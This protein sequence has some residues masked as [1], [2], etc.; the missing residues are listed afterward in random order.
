VIHATNELIQAMR[1]EICATSVAKISPGDE[2]S[3]CGVGGGIV[4]GCVEEESGGAA[5]PHL[6]VDC[7]R[8]LRLLFDS[9]E[10]V[11][12]DELLERGLI[13]GPPV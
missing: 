10:P 6:V 7:P 3:P 13:E 5:E 2:R 8:C 11:R 9:I 4:W 12:R 1:G